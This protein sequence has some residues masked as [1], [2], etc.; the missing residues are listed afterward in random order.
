[1]AGKSGLNLKNPEVYELARELARREGTTLT[2]TVLIA[3]REK[4]DRKTAEHDLAREKARLRASIER[5]KNLPD[6]TT[7]SHDELLGYG[8]AGYPE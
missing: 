1:M 4:L 5:M 8:P 6:L 7:K 3:L 2:E